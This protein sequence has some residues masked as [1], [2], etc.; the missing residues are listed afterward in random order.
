MLDPYY[1]AHCS[2]EIEY[3]FAEL[4]TSILEDIARRIY[5]NKYEMTSTARYQLN[6][7]KA[8]GMH[9]SE[10][11]K[12]ITE[13]LKISEQRVSEIISNA[14]Y[15]AVESDNLIFKEAYDRKL[16]NTFRYDK[17]SLSKLILKGV[18]A[19]NGEIRNICKTTAKT[20][21]KLLISSLDQTYLGIQS[22]A[23]SQQEAVGFAVDR[24]AKTGLQW[25]DYQS[26]THRRPDS[27][28][29]NV[30][31][32]GVN[33]TACKCQEK[34]FDDMGG[35]LVITTSHMGARPS[36]AE[37]QGKVFWWKKKYKNYQNFEQATGYG[38]GAGLGGWNC[39]H[40]FYPYFEGISNK[41]FEHYGISEN[42]EHYEL[43]QQQRY[44]E[45]KIR[46]WKRRQAVNKAGGV[47]NTREARKVREWQKRQ[48]DFLKAHPDMKRNYAREMIEKRT[49]TIKETTV[50]K[51]NKLLKGYETALK[52]GD[53]S[54][55]VTFDTYRSIAENIEKQL[56]GLKAK[57]GIIIS[58][59]KTHFIDR[60]IGQYESS[61]EP[62]K[63]M[64]KGVSIEEA[65]EALLSGVV[66]DMPLRGNGKPSRRYITDTCFV[67]LNPNTRELIQVT[68]K[69]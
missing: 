10:I 49:I 20:A 39:R 11:K 2:D 22:G 66:K 43:D 25:I 50:R 42:Q 1:L 32:S 64:R 54:S 16:I 15:E 28:I 13:I 14:A 29:R 38:T 3:L 30:I 59:Y 23:F 34:N 40:S 53:I 4:E 6:R 5:E 26:G 31:R 37:W 48:A 57:G 21:R 51:N 24:V 27:V 58:G 17:A 61:N 55:F 44:N 41:T 65:K 63:G 46:E 18:N 52:K 60:I 12:Q 19:T 7:A 68:P 47:D 45:R 36:H 9:N 62:V 33:Q 8:L 69:R 56:V 35:N 67:T